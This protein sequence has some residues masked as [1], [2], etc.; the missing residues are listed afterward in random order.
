MKVV[1]LVGMLAAVGCGGTTSSGGFEIDGVVQGAGAPPASH[2]VVL[3][4]LV[5]TGYKFGDGTA[6]DTAFTVTLETS[7]PAGAIVP[8]GIAV[9]YPL[10]VAD[11]TVVPDGPITDI[12]AIPYLGIPVDFAII[13]KDPT[14]AGLNMWDAAF[15]PNYSCGRCVHAQ[16]GHDTFELTPCGG[17]TIVFGATDPCNWS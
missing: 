8:G 16:S 15:G 3:W 6:T 5:D 13:W 11:G 7:P 17:F 1:F 12:T 14:G 4:D 9:G 10:L 2:V